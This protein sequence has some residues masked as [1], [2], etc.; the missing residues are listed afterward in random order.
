M[1]ERDAARALAGLRRAGLL[2]VP[3]PVD[4]ARPGRVLEGGRWRIDFASNDYLGLARD[5][6]L[7]RASAAAARRFG[8]GAGASRLITGTT[9]EHQALEREVA[10]WQGAPAALVLSSGFAA[11]LSVLTALARGATVFSDAANHASLIDACRLARCRVVV[12][13]HADMDALG[14]LLA[15][16]RRGNRKGACWIVTDSVFSVDGDMAPLADLTRLAGRH[17]ARLYVDE[18]HAVGV[19][20]HEG[21]GLAH[22]AGVAELVEVRMGTFSKAAGSYGAFVVGKR[23]VIDLLYNTARPFVFTTAIPA[24][25]CAATREALRILRREEWRRARLAENAARVREGLRARG[26][27]VPDGPTPVV[28]VRVGTPR[29]LARVGRRLER[30]GI[31]VGALRPPTVPAGACTFRVSVSAAHGTK[32]IDLLLEAFG[33]REARRFS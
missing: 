8:W 22:A 14:A 30:A 21:R 29:A 25:L 11:N 19:L 26:W 12:W 5:P 7:F 2:R 24:P 6:R 3:R 33:M 28:P 13:P 27:D 18:A 20:G 15:R 1:L 17:G 10:D 4:A 16:F 31:R 23:P 9:R 32:E